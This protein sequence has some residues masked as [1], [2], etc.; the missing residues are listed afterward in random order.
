MGSL[1]SPVRSTKKLSDLHRWCGS[2]ACW[3]LWACNSP[4]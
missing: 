1:S 2:L 3:W 4:P